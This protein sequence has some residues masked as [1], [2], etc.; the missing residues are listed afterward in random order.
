MVGTGSGHRP[1]HA[2][3]RPDRRQ[4]RLSAAHRVPLLQPGVRAARRGARTA[5][6]NALGRPAQRPAARP[7]RNAPHHVRGHRAVRP[8]LRRTPLARHAARGA[9]HRHRRDGPRRAALV[10]DRGPGPLGR[11]PRRPRPVGAG[12]RDAHRDVRARGDQRSRLLDR[13]ARPGA[14]ALPR[15]RARVRRA[16]RLDA[17]VRGRPRGAPAD[18]YRRGR[19]RQLVRLPDHRARPPAADHGA[20]RRAGVPAAVAAGHRR[21]RRRVGRADR[22]LVVDGHLA[23]PELGRG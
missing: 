6:R 17:R 13:R 22:P 7:A 18:P 4:D 19:L 9:P 3:R 8:R 16:R 21:A 14:G 5:H 20:G 23:G 2:A 10:D 11:V 1:G 12:R 15:R